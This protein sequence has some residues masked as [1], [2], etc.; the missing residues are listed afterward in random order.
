MQQGANATRRTKHGNNHRRAKGED[1]RLAI[2]ILY[3]EGNIA[4]S[5][6]LAR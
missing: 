4:A 1:Q 3:R 6:S 5:I 2:S